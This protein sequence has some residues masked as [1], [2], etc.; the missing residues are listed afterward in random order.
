VFEKAILG[1][2]KN[3]EVGTTKRALTLSLRQTLSGGVRKIF[4]RHFSD[5]ARGAE[6]STL[7]S[8]RRGRAIREA[9]LSTQ[10]LTILP[11][12]RRLVRRRSFQSTH[13]ASR[14]HYAASAQR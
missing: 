10:E 11:W 3:G 12:R 13:R 5:E 7:V 14:H 9:R 6:P 1:T 2:Q 8:R 4:G